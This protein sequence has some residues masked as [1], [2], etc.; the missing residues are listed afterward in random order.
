M[1]PIKI[2]FED[3]SFEVAAGKEAKVKIG[4]SNVEVEGLAYGGYLTIP[5]D[6]GDNSSVTGDI[7]LKPGDSII[8]GGRRFSAK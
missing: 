6:L 4:D 2:E 1:S 8:V 7:Q 5:E 3:S